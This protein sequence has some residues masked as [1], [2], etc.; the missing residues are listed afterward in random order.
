MFICLDA[1]SSTPHFPGIGRYAASLAAHLP[2]Q[3]LPGEQLVVLH[4]PEFPVPGG[5][6][7]RVGLHPCPV[8]PFSI[9][10]QWRIPRHLA[11]MGASLY[12]SPYYLMPYL[13]G[14]PAVVT[15]HDL[16]PLRFP[17]TV[18]PRA[19]LFFRLATLLALHSASQVITISNHTR[20]DI[21]AVFGSSMAAKIHAI[22][23]A[24][25]P[26]FYPQSPDA[27]ER[28][29]QKYHLPD[30]YVLYLGINKPHKNLVRLLHAWKNVL[31]QLPHPP[32]QLVIAGAWDERYPEPRQTVEELG[33][34][35]RVR[36]LGPIAEA[37]LPGLYSGSKVFVFP[38]LYE[39][40]GLPVLEALACGVPTA[41]SN[42][43][44]LTEAAGTA[45]E[46]FDPH[47]V[48]AITSA[49]MS[50]LG[51][52]ALAP[53]LR[54]NRLAQARQFSWEKTAQAT[55]EVYRLA[56]LGRRSSSLA[57]D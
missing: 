11:R 38:S 40:F 4:Q 23:L 28:V 22:P 32:D 43:S 44:S 49:L 56:A 50:C 16:I 31:V 20:D 57:G 35:E 9:A 7:S 54:E 29:R 53:D 17:G 1:R 46:Y 37:D 52:K 39:G 6:N 51:E 33:L 13:P 34:G 15:V 55:M 45:A 8:S 26:Q 25:G 48:E 27:I 24:A 36:F 41:C 14:V 21:L 2:S 3:L 30:S 47:N 42:T 5:D 18:S 12:H 10:Q 19:R